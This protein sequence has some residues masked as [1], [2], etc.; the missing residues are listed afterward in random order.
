MTI[1][2]PYCNERVDRTEQQLHYL[3]H[4]L[5]KLTSQ[6]ELLRDKIEQTNTIIERWIPEIVGAIRGER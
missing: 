6:V 5:L 1:N 2:C 4:Y 3:G